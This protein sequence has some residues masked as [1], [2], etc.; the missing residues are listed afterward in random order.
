MDGPHSLQATLLL[1]N[2]L[3]FVSSCDL[4]FLQVVSN[5]AIS[6]DTTPIDEGESRA[7]LVDDLV[8]RSRAELEIVQ[9]YG[10]FD[11]AVAYL[12]AAMQL[13]IDTADAVAALQ[14][15]LVDGFGALLG[16]GFAGMGFAKCR[17]RRG[18]ASLT[19]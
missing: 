8:Q 5:H 10:V 11:A 4:E 14:E 19:A 9:G 2:G 6:L 7:N 18:E 1:N 17:E 12:N 16:I 3:G 15:L 13:A